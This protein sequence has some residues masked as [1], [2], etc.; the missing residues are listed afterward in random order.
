M[1]QTV[2]DGPVADLGAVELEGVQAQGFRGGEAVGARRG[3]RET[4]SEE[5]GD[6][7]G[8]DG[9]VVSTREARAPQILF[10]VSAGLEVIGGER[11]ETAPGEAQL[12]GGFGGRQGVLPETREH[13][14]D[15][16]RGMTMG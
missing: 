13:M 7:F 1:G 11:I 8:P 5:V 14:A 15:E 16:G 10:L 6:R 4:L 2:L 12:G 3:A 9:G